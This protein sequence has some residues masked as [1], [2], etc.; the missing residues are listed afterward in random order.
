[1]DDDLDAV[2]GL[3]PEFA[4]DGAGLRSGA[5]WDRQANLPCHGRRT[6]F[7]LADSQDFLDGGTLDELLNVLLQLETLGC[8]HRMVVVGELEQ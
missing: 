8:R 1:M 4:H 7:R 6:C 2:R 3:E 5:R